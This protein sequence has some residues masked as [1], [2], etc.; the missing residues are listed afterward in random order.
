MRFLDSQWPKHAFQ[1]GGGGV[2]RFL[3]PI[4]LFKKS[5]NPAASIQSAPVPLPAPPVGADNQSVVQAEHDLARQALGK[6]SVK[7]TIFAGDTGGYGA[8]NSPM[9]K[10]G[11]PP[12]K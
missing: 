5:S 12:I 7:K 3:D 10:P 2:P 1:F 6:K 4:G 9:G 11:M 8:V